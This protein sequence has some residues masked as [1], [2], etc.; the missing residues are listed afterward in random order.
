MRFCTRDRYGAYWMPDPA[1]NQSR[2]PVLRKD[3][4]SMAGRL[5]TE[6][7][8]CCMCMRCLRQTEGASM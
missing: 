7:M 5:N 1:L 2:G 6:M 4:A 8:C 3:M